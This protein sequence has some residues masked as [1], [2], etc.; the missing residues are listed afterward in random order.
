MSEY[1]KPDPPSDDYEVLHSDEIPGDILPEGAM[2]FQ[3]AIRWRKSIFIGE[4]PVPESWYA[5]PRPLR[6][7][8]K[9]NAIVP[10]DVVRLKSGGPDMTVGYVDPDYVTCVW[11]YRENNTWSSTMERGTFGIRELEKVETIQPNRIA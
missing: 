3:G 7:N 10:G 4:K 5:I 8:E 6:G 2:Y 9:D 11:F 1:S